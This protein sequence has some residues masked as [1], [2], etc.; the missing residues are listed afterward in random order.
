MGSCQFLRS[1]DSITSTQ[2]Q[3]QYEEEVV[4]AAAVVRERSSR[5]DTH[6]RKLTKMGRRVT[7]HTQV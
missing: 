3:Q 7:T 4:V 5:S 2:Q 6:T 1:L